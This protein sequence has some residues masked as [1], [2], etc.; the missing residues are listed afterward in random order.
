M[1]E[2]V[3]AIIPARGGSR[4]IPKKNLRS[5]N[6]KPLISY[7]IKEALNSE[8]I[9]RVILST[10]SEEIAQVAREYGA[11]VP[12]KQSKETSSHDSSGLSCILEVLE[13]LKKFENYSP[14][15]VVYLQPTSPFR[16]TEQ[17]D[18]AIK[19]MLDDE[20]LDGAFGVIKVEHHPYMMFK[21]GENNLMIPALNIKDRPMRRQEF[22]ELYVTNASVYVIRGKYFDEARDPQ[23]YCPIFEGKVKAI[24]MDSFSSMDINEEKD[25]VIS[26]MMIKDKNDQNRE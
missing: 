2:K 9:D 18:Q 20:E 21:R 17:I 1:N 5:I 14:E 26:E 11:E 4:G 16:S 23:P 24:I 19:L 3:L 10:D 8:Y 13:K 25:L 6:G 12:F 7:T 15:I 22:P